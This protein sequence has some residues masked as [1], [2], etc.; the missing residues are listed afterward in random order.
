M[1]GMSSQQQSQ[2]TLKFVFPAAACQ[3][4]DIKI[5]ISEDWLTQCRGEYD[6]GGRGI[7]VW[8]HPR[9]WH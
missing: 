4:S 7:L 3:A 5:S 1:I 6:K 2:R 8:H 9:Y